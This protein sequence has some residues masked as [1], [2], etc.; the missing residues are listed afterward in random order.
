MAPPGSDPDVIPSAGGRLSVGSGGMSVAPSAAELP[1]HRIPGRLRARGIHKAR[2]DD[3][4]FV[5]SHG[6]GPFRDGPVATGLGLRLD[7]D[8]HGVVEPA[9]DMHVDEF[10]RKL[11]A[12]VNDWVVDEP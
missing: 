9:D 4:L 12:T 1:G 3:R 5:W 6:V 8:S 7:S 2:G 11:E 10:R